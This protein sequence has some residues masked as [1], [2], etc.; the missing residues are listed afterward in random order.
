MIRIIPK[1]NPNA[2]VLQN[3]GVATN[4]IK[5]QIQEVIT[6]E[7]RSKSFFSMIFGFNVKELT[8]DGHKI[9]TFKNGRKIYETIKHKGNKN[10]ERVFFNNEGQISE[11]KKFANGI[12][13]K[14]YE[15][16]L[17]RKGIKYKTVEFL[18]DVMIKSYFFKN[19]K[20]HLLE[21]N[22][23]DGGRRLLLNRADGSKRIS[24]KIYPNKNV[25]ISVFNANGILRKTVEITKATGIKETK[26]FAADGKT[27]IRTQTTKPIV[28]KK[29]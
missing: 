28:N 25:L 5:T 6:P 20:V 8:Q 16:S 7:I 3:P 10:F 12:V 14:L 27:I 15:Y 24:A 2:R 29:A 22:Y 19:G 4:T 9:T 23:N 13:P 11:I 26:R 1:I 18:D 17:F 21:K